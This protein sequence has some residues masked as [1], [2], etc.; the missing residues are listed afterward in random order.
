MT[1][2]EMTIVAIVVGAGLFLLVGWM[3]TLQQD[4]KHELAVRVLA[5]LDIALARYH[6]A[7][8]SYPTSHGPNSSIQ[9]TIDLL[10][11]DK[12]RHLLMALPASIWQ[13]SG[14]RNL[15]DPWGTP[16]QYLSADS[17]SKLVKAN[18][19]RPLF[20]SAGPD[21]DFGNDD[22]AGLGDNLRSDDPGTNG[23]RLQHALREAM[24]SKERADGEEDD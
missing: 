18:N 22:P 1:L 19:D 14:K 24:T 13:G 17:G 11:H 10:D 6:R 5:D 12:T 7:T 21:R 4:A 20:V 23:F 9:A 2:T 15:V 8:G 16:L 3:N